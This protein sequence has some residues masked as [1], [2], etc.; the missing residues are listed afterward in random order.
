MKARVERIW[1]RQRLDGLHHRAVVGGVHGRAGGVGDIVERPGGR[2]LAVELGEIGRHAAAEPRG[3][4]GGARRG[5]GLL[6]A[7]HL[8]PRRVGLHR[9]HV[10]RREDRHRRRREAR[11]GGRRRERGE[12]GRGIE[13][14]AGDDLEDDLG[15]GQLGEGAVAAEFGQAV[16]AA[17]VDLAG[18]PARR[19]AR[20]Q[21]AGRERVLGL[22][23]RNAE[24]DRRAAVPLLAADG[25]RARGPGSPRRAAAGMVAGDREPDRLR[26]R[27]ALRQRVGPGPGERADVGLVGGVGPVALVLHLEGVALHR[28]GRPGAGGDLVAD[29]ADVAERAARGRWPRGSAT[30]PRGR[31]RG[32][33]SPAVRRR[34]RPGAGR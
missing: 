34:R 4:E 19:E 28:A 31:R 2:A 14:A 22:P 23:G 10:L 29:R 26:H 6:E 20:E 27:L 18:E 13:A 5:V 8:R 32:G 11:L 12:L 30:A 9:H 21:V 7:R 16:A 33:W 15:A 17:E 25:D 24:A 1:W 3:R